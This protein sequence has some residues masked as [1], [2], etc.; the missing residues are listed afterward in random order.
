MVQDVVAQYKKEG[1]LPE[2][3]AVV[4]ILGEKPAGAARSDT[5]HG[6]LAFKAWLEAHPEM[7]KTRGLGF[8]NAPY[9]D[10][11]G[12]QAASCLQGSY[13]FEVVG[14]AENLTATLPPLDAKP[15]QG[16]WPLGDSLLVD[17]LDSVARTSYAL[18]AKLDYQQGLQA[19]A[20]AQKEK[21]EAE[22]L[23]AVAAPSYLPTQAVYL[24]KEK[25]RLNAEAEP[26]ATQAASAAASS[27]H[28]AKPK[29]GK[30]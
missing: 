17:A 30:L 11:Q 9:I 7:A 3:L 19:Q 20:Q 6:I 10:Y 14:P 13:D 5:S 15:A 2:D 18:K 29:L 21:L 16:F 12:E 26:P 25:V 1:K 24:E 4:T 27:A 8:S 28:H 23:R 22:T